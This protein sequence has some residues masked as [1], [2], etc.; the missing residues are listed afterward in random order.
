MLPTKEKKSRHHKPKLKYFQL[1][2]KVITNPKIQPPKKLQ[3]NSIDLKKNLKKTN[4]KYIHIH[5]LVTN[6]RMFK[7]HKKKHINI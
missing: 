3:V 1:V 5:T 4:K 7:S 6:T 2:N